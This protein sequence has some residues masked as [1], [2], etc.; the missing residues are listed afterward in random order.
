MSVDA[1]RRFGKTV[2]DPQFGLEGGKE[3]H[4]ILS[5]LLNKERATSKRMM[6]LFHCL[7]F[8]GL[9]PPLTLCI[10]LRFTNIHPMEF[11]K[12]FI[13]CT[14]LGTKLG[15]WVQCT[16]PVSWYPSLL[17]RQLN[18]FTLTLVQNLRGATQSGQTDFRAS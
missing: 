9:T 17:L 4:K 1:I 12:A 18:T 7:T 5:G 10:H 13:K 8:D 6:L 11:L 16:M 2:G 15:K 3:V 14:L